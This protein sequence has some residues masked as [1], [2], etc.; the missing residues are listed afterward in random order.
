MYI[1]QVASIRVYPVAASEGAEPDCVVGGDR[2]QIMR[3]GLWAEL[4]TALLARPQPAAAGRH[5]R[6]KCSRAV[7][8][9]SR[10]FTIPE[11]IRG[12]LFPAL[13]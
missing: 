9:F 10:D 5:V 11:N 13:M 8:E 2:D 6:T 1:D 7:N 3:P 12:P 4:D